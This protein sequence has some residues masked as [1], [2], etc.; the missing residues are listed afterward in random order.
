VAMVTYPDVSPEPDS[1][2]VERSYSAHQISDGTFLKDLMDVDVHSASSLHHLI[3]YYLEDPIL[4]PL[5]PW[6]RPPIQ[7]V[8][9]VYGLDLKTEIGYHFAPSGKP[10]PDNW[11]ISDIFFEN[12]GGTLQSRLVRGESQWY[13]KSSQWRYLGMI[14][15]VLGNY[16]VWYEV[17][18]Y[19][20]TLCRTA[21]HGWGLKSTSQELPRLH[22][23]CVTYNRS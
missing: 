10:Y 23:R 18:R 9:C 13:F 2:V 5:T 15:A 17:L 4:N 12:E 20:T 1:A 19:H 11:V 22:M 8:Y 7:N 6:T 14:F 16:Q 3:K 21:K